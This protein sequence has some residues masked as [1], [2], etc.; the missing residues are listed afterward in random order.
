[1]SGA[2]DERLW[3]LAAGLVRP[4]LT[5]EISTGRRGEG[6]GM[7]EVSDNSSTNPILREVYLFLGVWVLTFARLAEEVIICKRRFGREQRSRGRRPTLR[8]RPQSERERVHV[9]A[10]TLCTHVCNFQCA[11]NKVV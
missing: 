10:A 7:M 8:Q 9:G 2:T 3:P 5:D 11:C 6:N 4:S 1:M